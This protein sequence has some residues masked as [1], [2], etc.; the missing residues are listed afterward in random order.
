MV[1]SQVSGFQSLR[2]I[3][4]LSWQQKCLLGGHRKGPAGLTLGHEGLHA[5]APT[6]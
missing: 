2:K 5:G 3:V 1:S 6:A 4:T